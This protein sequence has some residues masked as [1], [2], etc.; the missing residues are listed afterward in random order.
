MNQPHHQERCLWLAVDALLARAAYRALLRR[1]GVV[2][3]MG[4]RLP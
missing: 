3:V 2:L 1:M 4:V